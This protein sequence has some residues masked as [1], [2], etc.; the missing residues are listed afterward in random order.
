MKSKYLFHG[1]N[2]ILFILL[3]I[4]RL[5]SLYALLS[6]IQQS[7]YCWNNALDI[8]PKTS[9]QLI[10]IQL[11]KHIWNVTGVVYAWAVKRLGHLSL[12]AQVD[13]LNPAGGIPVIHMGLWPPL[14]PGRERWPI[15][16]L[17]TFTSTAPTVQGKN[18]GTCSTSLRCLYCMIGLPLS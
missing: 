11:N 5:P 16:M 18:T 7:I 17:I 12:M 9:A 2:D 10:S 13:S 14:E 15:M 1:W 4:F 6:Y 8:M 3:F